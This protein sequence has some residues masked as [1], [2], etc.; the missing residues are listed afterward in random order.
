MDKKSDKSSRELIVYFVLALMFGLISIPASKIIALSYYPSS[1]FVRLNL[2]WLFWLSI[3]LSI[4]CTIPL[5]RAFVYAL[6]IR[7]SLPKTIDWLF[8]DE[9]SQRIGIVI[10]RL[11][12]KVFGVIGRLVFAG[13]GILLIVMLL[14]RTGVIHN[15]QVDSNAYALAQ[16]LIGTHSKVVDSSIVSMF[17]FLRRHEPG[18]YLECLK[19][20][21]DLKTAGVKVVLL[22]L[23]DFRNDKESLKL[24]REL[25]ETGIVVFATPYGFNFRTADSLGEMQY[26]KGTFTLAERD[27]EESIGL[28]RI[29]PLGTQGLFAD[30]LAD[31]TI[32]VLRKYKSYAR[33]LPMKRRVNEIQFGEFTIPVTSDGSMYSRYNTGNGRMTVVGN[34]DGT[35]MYTNPNVGKFLY[36]D[37]KESVVTNSGFTRSLFSN[38]SKELG[39]EMQGTIVFLSESFGIDRTQMPSAYASAVENILAGKVTRKSETGYLWLSVVC[40]VIAGFV[41]YRF[42]MVGAIL[43]MFILAVCTLLFG[44]YLYDGQNILV[45]IF[46]PLLSIA[47]AMVAFSAITLGHRVVKRE[48]PAPDYT[49][50]V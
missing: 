35:W 12:S 34:E 14:F 36:R 29:K 17:T 45:D 24:M 9:I 48:E 26:S 31:V 41:A 4:L 16:S 42:R 13:I 28:C 20:V 38:S 7:G 21:R 23:A 43:L 10:E 39:K 46:Y 44:A 33:D 47:M 30:P 50:P 27:M 8:A 19:L 40:L 32:E 22:R 25:E 5:L 49:L 15:D 2:R 6:H 18:Y 3:T 37:L 11:R 1:G